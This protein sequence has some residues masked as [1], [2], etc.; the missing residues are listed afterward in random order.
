MELLEFLQRRFPALVEIV[1][2]IL[3]V[4]ALLAL[5]RSFSANDRDGNFAQP[6]LAQEFVWRQVAEIVAADV[7]DRDYR[8]SAILGEEKEGRGE[9]RFHVHFAPPDFR[10][11]MAAA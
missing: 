3:Q 7:L 5:L 10:A 9:V 4:D 8:L 6:H 1:C 2:Q 11:R